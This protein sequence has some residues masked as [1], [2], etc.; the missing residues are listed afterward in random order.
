MHF[1]LEDPFVESKTFAA[2][3]GATPRSIE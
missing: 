3:P 1:S 2:C